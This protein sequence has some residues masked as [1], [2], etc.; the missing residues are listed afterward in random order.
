MQ[1]E[2]VLSVTAICATDQCNVQ[3]ATDV[4]LVNDMCNDFVVELIPEKSPLKSNENVLP[5]FKNS[6][7]FTI[8]LFRLLWIL[9]S[10]L[11]AEMGLVMCFSDAH[12]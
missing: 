11:F 10:R 7:R 5:S 12:E 8:S 6:N 4:R 1:L 2:N 3:S 9:L